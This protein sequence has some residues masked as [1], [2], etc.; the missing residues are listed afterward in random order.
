MRELTHYKTDIGYFD[1][2]NDNLEG[3]FML[4]FHLDYDMSQ[5]GVVAIVLSHYDAQMSTFTE[6][7]LYTLNDQQSTILQVV[8]RG[9]YAVSIQSINSTPQ[10]FQTL[11]FS[12]Q[13]L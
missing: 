8:E 4:Y 12:K 1:F 5:E 7:G 6:I 13:K 2:E 11:G 9:T 3:P 10:K